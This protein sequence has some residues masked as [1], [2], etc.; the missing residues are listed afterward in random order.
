MSNIV[1]NNILR[2]VVVRNFHFEKKV[3]I[4]IYSYICIL[5]QQGLIQKEKVDTDGKEGTQ[6]SNVAKKNCNTRK[7]PDYYYEIKTEH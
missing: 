2:S 4:C 3:C 6:I 7:S 5:W 1:R